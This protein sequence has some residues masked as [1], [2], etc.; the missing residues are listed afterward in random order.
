MYVQIQWPTTQHPDLQHTS[1]NPITTRLTAHTTPLPPSDSS[2]LMTLLEAAR[3]CIDQY[4]SIKMPQNS[5][6][7]RD[8]SENTVA[9]RP[10]RM[11]PECYRNTYQDLANL[12]P[13]CE[14]TERCNGCSRPTSGSPLRIVTSSLIKLVFTK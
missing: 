11:L 14:T 12:E 3:L 4:V 9:L 7:Q 10:A 2:D 6:R 13:S 5:L 1:Y 8:K